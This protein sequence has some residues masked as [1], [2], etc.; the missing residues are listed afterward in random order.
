MNCEEFRLKLDAWV[1]GE[2]T[3]AEMDAVLDH[4]KACEACMEELK[5]AQLLKET[6]A[7]MDDEISV[8]LQAQAAW[9]NAVRA[10]SRR[11]NARKWTRICSAAAAAL[12]LALGLGI[13]AQQ[14]PAA[15]PEIS[16]ARS[17]EYAET[18]MVLADGAS[19]DEAAEIHL[20]Q[21]IQT[22]S[23]QEALHKLEQ[24]AGEYSGKYTPQGDDACII[25]LPGDYLQDFISAEGALGELI[26]TETVSEAG[27]T[28]VLLIQLTE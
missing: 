9:R 8:P 7:H 20:H 24:L 6:L 15:Q 16:L 26:H 12:V 1:D 5:A 28:V 25:C 11:K 18:A 4:A 2:L 17:M 19:S 22:A 27:E 3:P 21:K 14:K 23:V 13:T 10:E